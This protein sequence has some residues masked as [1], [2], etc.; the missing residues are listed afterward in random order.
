MNPVT[1][2]ANMKSVL[3][4]IV[5][6]MSLWMVICMVGGCTVLRAASGKRPNELSIL[7]AGQDRSVLLE[8]WGQPRKSVVIEG[9]RR[10]TFLVQTG[11]ASGGGRALG[12]ATMDVL[13]MG[14]WELVGGGIEDGHSKGL[15][16]T[17]EYDQNDKVT[18]AYPGDV[19]SRRE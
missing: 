3:K 2:N 18:D 13:T 1:I 11:D 10:D 12:H 15:W 7:Y 17:V 19:G 5:C 4:C 6:A 8:R 9:K 14:T 16:L